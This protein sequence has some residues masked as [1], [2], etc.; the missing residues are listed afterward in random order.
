MKKVTKNI[1]RHYEQ[2]NSDCVSLIDMSHT[3]N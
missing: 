3:T 2:R 1:V